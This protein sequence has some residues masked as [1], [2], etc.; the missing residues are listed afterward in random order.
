MSAVDGSVCARGVV[1]RTREEVK[2]SSDVL[3]SCRPS[4]CISP[5]LSASSADF[6]EGVFSRDASSSAMS[7]R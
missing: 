7:V 2:L 1:G 4:V 5:T 6:I 3:L